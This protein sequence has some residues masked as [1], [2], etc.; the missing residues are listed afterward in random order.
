MMVDFDILTESVKAEFAAK[1]KL[2]PLNMKA[3]ERGRQAAGK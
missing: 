3:L 1:A 2:I